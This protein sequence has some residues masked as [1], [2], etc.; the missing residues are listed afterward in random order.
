MCDDAFISFRV[1]DNFV[2]GFGLRWNPVERVQ[3]FTNPLWMLLH[4]P[5]HWV[6]GNIWL[7]TQI[8]SFCC[9]LSAVLLLANTFPKRP[10]I[11][12]V[13][14]LVPFFLSHCLMDYTSS[15]LENPLTYLLFA[16]FGWVLVRGKRSFFWFWLSLSTALLMVNRLDTGLMVAPVLIF[17]VITRWRSVSFLQ[18]ACG[19]L[20][21]A[22]WALFSLWYY[23]FLFPNT[24]YAKLHTDLPAG[25]LMTQGF[26]YLQDFWFT[27]TPSVMLMVAA[28]FILVITRLRGRQSQRFG[29]ELSLFLGVVLTCIY[30]I[31]VGG[32][33]MSGRFFSLP[34]LVCLWLVYGSAPKTALPLLVL[35]PLLLMGGRFYSTVAGES[36]YGA[37]HPPWNAYGI[38][39]ERQFYKKTLG[40]F[41]AG[42]WTPRFHHGADPQLE[43]ELKKAKAGDGETTVVKDTVGLFGYYA[44]PTVTVVDNLGV[45]DPLLAR[46]PTVSRRGWRIGHFNRRIP[47]GYLAAMAH[48]DFRSMEENLADYYQNLQ[49]VTRDDLGGPGRIKTIIAFNSGKFDSLLRRYAD[50][51]IS[52]TMPVLNINNTSDKPATVRV[53]VPDFKGKETE[54]IAFSLP[55]KGFSTLSLN[56]YLPFSKGE[57]P[58]TFVVHGDVS[59]IQGS[60]ISLPTQGI[61]GRTQ[62]VSHP[63]FPSWG[64]RFELR[65]LARLASDVSPRNPLFSANGLQTE[66]G[67]DRLPVTR[68]LFPW[69]SASA[70]FETELAIFNGN[71]DPVSLGFTARRL[72]GETLQTQRQ[73]A[74]NQS[75]RIQASSL[76]P[77]M[78]PGGFSLVLQADPAPVWARWVTR[79]LNLEPGGPLQWRRP[80]SMEQYSQP[81]VSRL[82]FPLL[83]VDGD[84]KSLP[85]LVNTG[86]QSHPLT[87]TGYDDQGRQVF[88]E[89]QPGQ[90]PFQPWVFLA[91]ERV[92]VG[93]GNISLWIQSESEI[94]AIA[95]VLK[96]GHEPVIV[97][98]QPVDR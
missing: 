87:I 20:P 2:N 53:E 95:L 88:R 42:S 31:A 65:P 26:R 36:W 57:E 19:A 7:I 47:R 32:D 27:D 72:S 78:E 90:S 1:V 29:I 85:V 96:N 63:E 37:A 10:A 16:C 51:V 9:S 25:E 54:P 70:E 82:F 4:I 28:A 76:F 46:L 34:V 41:E 74:A 13:V 69:V 79:N 91:N 35:W 38:A 83:P 98:E 21:L 22:A 60:L 61:Q 44:G 39:N 64:M 11:A 66:N 24:K 23:G 45:T 59:Q 77:T 30:I 50:S 94:R 73:I 49:R 84:F 52:Q 67:L 8:L 33:F 97:D 62:W 6:T 86:N 55:P 92:P 3:T 71:K 89:R 68:L 18:V 80:L 93:V 81:R 58:M 15:G 12:I 40:L 56:E 14:L 17:L 75:L 5:F 48:G 43:K